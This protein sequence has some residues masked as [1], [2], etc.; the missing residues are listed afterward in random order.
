M[1]KE[2]LPRF[3]TPEG[4]MKYPWILT[5]NT[6]FN[7]DGEYQLTLI[8]D[9]DKAD[10]LIA[11]INAVVDEKFNAVYN[12]AS[13]KVRKNLKKQYPYASEYI[14]NEEGEE[15][16]TGRTEFKFKQAVKVTSKKTGK[17]YEL[18]VD[19]FD[20]F[21]RKLAENTQVWS[22]STGIVNYSMRDYYIPATGLVGVKLQLNAVQIKTLVQGGGGTAEAYGFEAEEMDDSEDFDAPEDQNSPAVD[23]D[24]P[25]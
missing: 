21:N 9:G 1:A 14:V 22:G 6:K 7:P 12:E 8:L 3:S 11:K 13:A 2:K 18:R 4:E 23:D 17:T 5:P 20:K 25:F 16:E 10:K 24:I 19:V 15:E